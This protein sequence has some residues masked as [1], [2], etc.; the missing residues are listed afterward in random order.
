VETDLTAPPAF[1]SIDWQAPWLADWR[2][3]AAALTGAD[4]RAALNAR[5]AEE[6]LINARG[7]P[8]RFVA[9]QALPEGEAYEAYIGETGGVPT[10]DN[11]HDFFNALIWLSYPNIKRSLNAIQARELAAGGVGQTRGKLR[12]MATVFDENAALFACADLAAAEAL[13][14]HDWQCLFLDWRNAFGTVCEVFPFGHALLEKLTVPF[15]AITAHAWVVDVDAAF[16]Q[17]PRM[18]QRNV[19]DVIVAHQ[20][21]TGLQET[22]FTPL[23]V[24]GVPGWAEGQDAGYYRDKSVFR[25]KRN[26]PNTEC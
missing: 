15:K 24:L 20:L 14:A 26:K 25:P 18:E 3:S 16:F 12:D 6:N 4:W 11:L 13:R 8:L 21:A 7:L 19:L 2:A 17:L 10:R 9:Q 22:G 23:P 5:A 1:D